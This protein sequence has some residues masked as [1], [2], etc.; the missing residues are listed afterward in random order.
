MVTNM[1]TFLFPHVLA[2]LVPKG[3]A[4]VSHIPHTAKNGCIYIYIY[5]YQKNTQIIVKWTTTHIFSFSWLFFK[6]SLSST[7]AKFF[8]KNTTLALY[9]KIWKFWILHH[10]TTV[11]SMLYHHN[12]HWTSE[13]TLVKRRWIPIPRHE[14]KGKFCV[15]HCQMFSTCL[16]K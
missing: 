11:A 2:V 4:S 14:T 1:S 9:F 12:P 5:I 7:S 15:Y 6:W 3:P 16:S 8:K 10:P 13:I